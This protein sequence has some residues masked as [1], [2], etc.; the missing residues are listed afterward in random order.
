MVLCAERPGYALSLSIS[1]MAL[2][3]NARRCIILCMTQDVVPRPILREAV[4]EEIRAL[5]AR[6]RMSGAA[7]AAKIDKSEMYLSRRLRAETAFDIDDLEQIAT[8][9]GTTPGH[10]ISDAVHA[11]TAAAASQDATSQKPRKMTKPQ[12]RPHVPTRP[13]EHRHATRPPNYP[14]SARRPQLLGSAV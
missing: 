2:H 6:R 12:V 10:L 5:L 8:A 3:S 13:G 7:L 1:R 11:R 9:L 14:P 4:A